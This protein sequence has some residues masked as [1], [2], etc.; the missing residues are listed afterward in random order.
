L[1]VEQR[2]KKEGGRFSITKRER[3]SLFL[4]FYGSRGKREGS[5]SEETY[6]GPYKEGRPSRKLGKKRSFAVGKVKGRNCAPS[7]GWG[8]GNKGWK[9]GKVLCALIERE[10]GKGGAARIRCT[11]GNPQASTPS[12]STRE[13]EKKGIGPFQKRKKRASY[14]NTKGRKVLEI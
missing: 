3:T 7:Q 11:K 14:P 9:V 1:P 2:V 6:N 10:E 5:L 13:G 12:K 8:R 4:Q